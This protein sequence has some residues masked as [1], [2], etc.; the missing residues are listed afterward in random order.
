MKLFLPKLSDQ[1]YFGLGAVGAD[2]WRLLVETGNVAGV[3]DVL[4]ESYAGDPAT[5]R[6]TFT[7]WRANFSKRGC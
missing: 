3:A 5:I 2:A 4:C 6:G 7:L 1:Q